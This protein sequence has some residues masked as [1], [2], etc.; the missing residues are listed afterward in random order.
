MKIEKKGNLTILHLKE[1]TY[2]KRKL[3]FLGLFLLY[4]V[5]TAFFFWTFVLPNLSFQNIIGSLILLVIS[6]AYFFISYTFLKQIVSYET[7]A[8][9]E[10]KIVIE[11]KDLQNTSHQSF[12]IHRIQNLRYKYQAEPTV[13][14][15]LKGKSIDY[16]GFGANDKII[17]HSHRD[18]SIVFEYEGDRFRFGKHLYSWDF[19]KIYE[20]I[21]H[22]PYLDENEEIHPHHS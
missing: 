10:G 9:G 8:I 19:E 7:I 22:K 12:D 21:Y 16:F 1:N 3:L 6:G 4:F 14:H 2:K 11:K 13:D 17:Q 5:M 15:P 18:D 20:L